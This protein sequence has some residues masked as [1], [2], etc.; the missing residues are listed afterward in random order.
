MKVGRRVLGIEL[1]GSCQVPQSGRQVSPED[2]HGAA[3]DV[4]S[5]RTRILVQGCITVGESLVEAVYLCECS[6]TVRQSL[7]QTRVNLQRRAIIAQSPV[8]VSA[9]G[10]EL[11]SGMESPRVTRIAPDRLRQ[12]SQGKARFPDF[13]RRFAAQVVLMRVVL[14]QMQGS[15]EAAERL[16][17]LPVELIGDA[18]FAIMTRVVRVE[19]EGPVEIGNRLLESAGIPVSNSAAGVSADVKRV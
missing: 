6:G 13:R 8:Q 10:V 11:A 1:D 5:A 12:I 15:I 4:Y 14:I 19:R 16:L 3:N 2:Q 17:V 9:F 7:G 18:A